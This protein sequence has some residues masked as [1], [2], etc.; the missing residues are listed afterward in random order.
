[1]I[2]SAAPTLRAAEPATAFLSL[3]PSLELAFVV[4]FGLVAGSFLNAA[5]HRLPEPELSLT[6]PRRSL[7]PKCGHGL[8]WRENVPLLSWIVQRGRCR[9]CSAPISVRYPLVEVLTAGLFVWAWF[10]TEH[11]SLGLLA[12]RWLVLA[13]LV[14]S[15]FVDFDRFEIPDEVSIGGMVL[16]PI[17]SL[18]VPRLHEATWVAQQV[19]EGSGVDRMG[20]LVGSLA[21]L[22][23][24]GGVLLAIGKL[25]SWVYGRDAMGF[26]D[27]KLLAAGGGFVGPGGAL[28]ALAIGSCVA[29]VAGAGNLVRFTCLIRRRARARGVPKRLGR[30]LAAGRIAGRYLPFG[31]YLGIGIG[32]ALLAWNHL[33]RVLP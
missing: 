20:A 30:A 13:G 19:S 11:D 16:A 2:A 10:A 6:R 9:W 29:S 5:I 31:P 15:T 12:V 23:V 25:G 32:I 3:P 14:V 7:C 28:V 17:L 26:G 4:V 24:G 21:G 18:A 33:T 1:M 8:T 27:V 22:A